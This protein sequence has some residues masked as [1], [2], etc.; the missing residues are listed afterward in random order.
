VRS[1]FL[2]VENYQFGPFHELVPILYC[3]ETRSDL[4]KDGSLFPV[5]LDSRGYTAVTTSLCTGL[6]LY[7]ALSEPTRR[8]ES[9]ILFLTVAVTL[10]L[11]PLYELLLYIALSEPKEDPEN[12][13]HIFPIAL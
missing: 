8:P 9:S 4:I 12:S 6:L 7:I 3:K 13:S 1:F 2:W 5:V 10:R 11:L